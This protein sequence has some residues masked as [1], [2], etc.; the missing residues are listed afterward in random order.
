MRAMSSDPAVANDAIGVA[1]ALLLSGPGL[2]ASHLHLACYG[3]G[4]VLIA[5]AWLEERRLSRG[6]P[7]PAASVADL[8]HL[9]H[10]PQLLGLALIA[11]GLA[12]QTRWTPFSLLAVAP[13]LLYLLSRVVKR[14]GA[15]VGREFSDAARAE[16]EGAGKPLPTFRSR[17]R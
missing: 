6:T 8:T 2:L 15:R 1:V 12:V 7:G 11:A 16:Q 3:V 13:L 10:D 5:L 14:R 4:L 9:F 17:F